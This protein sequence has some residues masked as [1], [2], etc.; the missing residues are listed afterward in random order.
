LL[1]FLL[2]GCFPF[3]DEER[4]YAELYK[5]IIAVD[6]VFPEKPK[7]SQDA[8]NFI[9]KLLVKDPE[10][11]YTPQ[12]CRDHPWLKNTKLPWA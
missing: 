2:T 7:L 10:R 8:K 1:T 4:N 5:K 6:Y 3:Y 12:L 11:R 9:G